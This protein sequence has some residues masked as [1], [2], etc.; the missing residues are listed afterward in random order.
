MRV[1]LRKY[2]SHLLPLGKRWSWNSTHTLYTYTQLCRY[3]SSQ[4]ERLSKS[5]TQSE[6]PSC[7]RHCSGIHG[8]L[9]PQSISPLHTLEVLSHFSSFFFLLHSTSFVLIACSRLFSQDISECRPREKIDG[10]FAG[11]Q[12]MRLTLSR[13]RAIIILFVASPL[14]LSRLLTYFLRCLAHKHTHK[15]F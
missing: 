12:Q 10:I 2:P 8:P 9:C 11:Q 5:A 1:P 15:K 3:F 14:S 7:L 4:E 13:R 6:M